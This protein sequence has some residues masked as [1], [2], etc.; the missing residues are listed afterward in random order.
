MMTTK[1]TVVDGAD[2]L[3]P[4]MLRKRPRRRETFSHY[5]IYYK[6]KF[7]KEQ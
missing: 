1:I 7:N 5:M 4:D 6:N 3:T 2:G